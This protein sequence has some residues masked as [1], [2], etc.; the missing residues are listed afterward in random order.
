MSGAGGREDADGRTFDVACE[1]VCLGGGVASGT[2]LAGG[3]GGVMVVPIGGVMVVPV[4]RGADI[5]S[6]KARLTE[7]R[8][9][10]G[11]MV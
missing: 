9:C 1:Y 10:V 11:K 2:V 4:V 3:I 5:A 7:N 8:M 6:S